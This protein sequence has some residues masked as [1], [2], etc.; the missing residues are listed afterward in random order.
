MS[1][2]N[3]IDKERQDGLISSWLKEVKMKDFQK[4]YEVV[5][6]EKKVFIDADFNEN[7]ML[8]IKKISPSA[9]IYDNEQ[10][11]VR[12]IKNKS[13]TALALDP[14]GTHILSVNLKDSEGVSSKIQVP[15]LFDYV[16][17]WN[18]RID[19]Y[20]KTMQHE[21][22]IIYFFVSLFMSARVVYV[23]TALLVYVVVM[24]LIASIL[25]KAY[26]ANVLQGL[27]LLLGLILVW[28]IFT[29]SCF[30]FLRYLTYCIR[31][32]F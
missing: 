23:T 10:F 30:L 8:N 4:F 6:D 28:L 31:L 15:F 18:S 22:P 21:V 29:F 24:D 19:N 12:R 1:S 27:G 20:G 25:F 14:S 3:Y 5:F 7:E 2:H 17:R 9:I 26:W 11:F 13:K 32:L 16:S